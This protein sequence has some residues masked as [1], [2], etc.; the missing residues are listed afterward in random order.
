M[1][2]AFP[3][4]VLLMI[5]FFSCNTGHFEKQNQLSLIPYPAE[6]QNGK[7]QFELSAKTGLVVND[8]GLFTSEVNELQSLIKKTLGQ[9]LSLEKGKNT[10]V[11]QVSDKALRDRKSTRLN[12]SH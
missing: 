11:I 4:L 7:G 2:K 6:L 3:A 8:K 9:T 12:S 10:I 5:V 1:K